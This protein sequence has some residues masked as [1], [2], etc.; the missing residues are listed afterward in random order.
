MN[1]EP[2]IVCVD[3]GALSDLMFWEQMARALEQAGVLRPA[4]IVLM[5]SSEQA[6]AATGGLLS[7]GVRRFGELAVSVDTNAAFERAIRE[8]NKAAVVRLADA[9]VSAVGFTG[10]DRGLLTWRDG[11]LDV[12][13][14]HPIATLASSGVVCVVS[15]VA[16]GPVWTDIHPLR[17]AAGVRAKM[18]WVCPFTVMAQ[19]ITAGYPEPGT[20]LSGADVVTLVEEGGLSPET[21]RLVDEPVLVAH[22]S[23]WIL[24]RKS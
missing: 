4:P 1:S 2:S 21:V 10:A 20:A 11:Q 7:T 19:R 6:E 22:S 3:H 5:G 9:G 8:Q 14:W 15:C 13:S 18:N 17:V 16:A 12:G 23:R 24:V